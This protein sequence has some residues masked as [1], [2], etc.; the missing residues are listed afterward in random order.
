MKLSSGTVPVYNTSRNLIY[1]QSNYVKE[2]IKISK[3]PV[4]RVFFYKLG[5]SCASR[6]DLYTNRKRIYLLTVL[7]LLRVLRRRG[8][9]CIV[10]NLGCGDGYFAGRVSRFRF[11]VLAV[12]I[13]PSPLWSLRCG[14]N[15]DFI[16]ADARRLPLHT[17]SVDFVY[18]LSL[19]EYVDFQ[20]TFGDSV[21]PILFIP[22]F[23]GYLPCL[24]IYYP[25]TVVIT[26][27]LERGIFQV[28]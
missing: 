20:S 28:V 24:I 6:F 22:T 18:A 5:V 10:L 23:R 15:T 7:R 9:K 25:C 21:L 2:L 1:L 3:Q 16:V 27:H 17:G 19:L 14:S 4:S 8:R 26:R 12:D 13:K 11:H